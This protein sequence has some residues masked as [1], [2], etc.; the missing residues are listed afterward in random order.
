MLPIH[1]DDLSMFLDVP[2]K[3]RQKYDAYLLD[4]RRNKF[5]NCVCSLNWLTP[6]IPTLVQ[7]SGTYLLYKLNYSPAHFVKISK[8]CYHGNRRTRKMTLTCFGE[9]SSYL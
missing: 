6:K 7:E 4:L 2:T 3:K 9:C 5:L 8:F 1:Q